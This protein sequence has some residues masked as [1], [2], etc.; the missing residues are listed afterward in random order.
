[1]SKDRPDEPRR[2]KTD[3]QRELEQALD[4]GLRETF[5]GSD[6]VSVVQPAP[7]KYDGRLK[8]EPEATG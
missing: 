6:P 5:P 8:R 1:M 2:G 4:E 3:H 7:S